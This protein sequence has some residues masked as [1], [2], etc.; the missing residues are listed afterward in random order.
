[1]ADS[2]GQPT[3]RRRQ[4][5]A[6]SRTDVPRG[7]DPTP[8]WLGETQTRTDVGLSRSFYEENTPPH[9]GA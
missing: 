4:R 5:R 1:M 3:P 9:H 2:H 6:P 7:G 8:P